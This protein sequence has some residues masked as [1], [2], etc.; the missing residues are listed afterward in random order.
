MAEKRYIEKKNWEKY[1][2]KKHLDEHSRSISDK[3]NDK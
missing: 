1:W 3:Y 2:E